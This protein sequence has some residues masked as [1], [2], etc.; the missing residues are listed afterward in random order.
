MKKLFV[1]CCV[2]ALAAACRPT[3]DMTSEPGAHAGVD[4]ENRLNQHTDQGL[5]VDTGDHKYDHHFN[6]KE[7]ETPAHD[8][9]QTAPG[10]AAAAT[11]APADTAK[12][13]EAKAAEPKAAEAHK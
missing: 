8:E 7:P 5:A 6:A 10:A 1:M 3:P 12:P 2:A 9:A 13:A 4:S 11:A